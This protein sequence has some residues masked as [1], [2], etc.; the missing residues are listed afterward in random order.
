MTKT[1]ERKCIVPGHEDRKYFARG[2]C[3]GCWKAL[4]RAGILKPLE[5]DESR[6][7]SLIQ[8]LNLHELNYLKLEIDN[9]IASI[10]MELILERD[11]GAALC[12]VI[13]NHT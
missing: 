6:Y 11:S 4:R 9:R 12:D 8:K 7:I 2:F 5:F 1:S 3:A 13:E 10:E